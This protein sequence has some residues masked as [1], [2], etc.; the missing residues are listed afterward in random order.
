MTIVV[1]TITRELKG[2]QGLIKIKFPK[3][4]SFTN[5]VKDVT[6]TIFYTEGVCALSDSV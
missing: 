5:V 4:V 1:G 6:K 2:G 3:V